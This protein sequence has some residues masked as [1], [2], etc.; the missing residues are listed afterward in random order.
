MYRQ[1]LIE[2]KEEVLAGL[3]MKF[4][5]L[6]AMGR[7]AEEDKAQLSHDEFVS[8][9]L[10]SLDHLQ[11]RMVNEALD[12]LAAGDYGTCLSCDQPIPAKRLEA[13]PWT[14][15][16]VACQ[17]SIGLQDLSEPEPRFR[18]LHSTTGHR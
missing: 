7:I 6:A 12:R 9:R 8:L 17:D 10:N 1:A 5:T 16:C 4:D 2:K 13:V 15:Y 3:G 11:L 14:R 18:M